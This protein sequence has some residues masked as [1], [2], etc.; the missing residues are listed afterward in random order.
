MYFGVI[1]S[2]EVNRHTVRRT[3]FV[4]MVLL[5]RLVSDGPQLQITSARPHGQHSVGTGYF[6][7][8]SNRIERYMLLFFGS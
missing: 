5:L 1:E 2:W 4:S 7:G 6:K 8:M 3:D